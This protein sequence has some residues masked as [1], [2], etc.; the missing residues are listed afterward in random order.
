MRPRSVTRSRPTATGRERRVALPAGSCGS[1]QCP[2]GPLRARLGNL[3]EPDYTVFHVDAPGLD[4]NRDN[5]PADRPKFPVDPARRGGSSH[6]GCSA[7]CTCDLEGRLPA[8]ADAPSG[9][10]GERPYTPYPERRNLD[11]PLEGAPF[12]HGSATLQKFVIKCV[13]ECPSGV[14]I[15]FHS[16][17]RRPV[18]ANA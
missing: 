17:K 18:V 2:A 14:F 9:A 7:G 13:D 4:A 15:Q 8:F 16:L 5:G 11:C 3:R 10:S 12:R 6:R 1:A